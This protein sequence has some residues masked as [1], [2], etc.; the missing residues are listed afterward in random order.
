MNSI[1]AI[2]IL[3]ICVLFSQLVAQN[4]LDGPVYDSSEIDIRHFSKTDISKLK[5]D[6]D[7]DY[8]QSPAGVNLWERFKRW[9]GNMVNQLFRAAVSADWTIIL[10]VT[11]AILLIVY[12][13]LR[14]LKVDALKMMY[15]GK[16]DSVSYGVL[17]EDIHAMDFDQM[18]R[19]ALQRKEF[20]LAIRLQFLQALKLLA[21]NHHIVWQPGKTNHDYLDELKA[22]TLKTG[23]NELNFYF[24]YAWYGN[25]T[26]TES[27]YK[28]VD[29]LFTHWRTIV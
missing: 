5:S 9:L 18:I 8:G 22:K 6:P 17:D 26:I 25:F 12:V 20:R 19:N 21:D 13:V 11:L 16:N 28:K 23:F 2:L 1:R 15:T 24:E 7:M 3:F 10:I 4:S 27:H 14:L 29:S